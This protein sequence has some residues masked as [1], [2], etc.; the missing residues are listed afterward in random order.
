MKN[1]Y[2]NSFRGENKNSIDVVFLGNSSAYKSITPL[3]IWKEYGYTSFVCGAPA[4]E[5]HEAYNMLKDFMKVQK[6]KIVF[7]E[8]EGIFNSFGKKIKGEYPEL[9]RNLI[10]MS[11]EIDGANEF[12][13]TE[14]EQLCPFLKNH[15]RWSRI[16]FDDFTLTPDYT[17]HYPT[18]GYVIE[19]KVKPYTGTKNYMESSD[20][21]T[22]IQMTV[23][24]YLD[25]IRDICRQNDAELILLSSPLPRAWNDERHKAVQNYA[26]ENGL[27]YIDT[28]LLIKD[29]GIDWKKDSSDDGYHLNINGARKHTA[30]IGRYLSENY[31]LTD[32]RTDSIY[33]QWNNDYEA[34]LKEIKKG[35]KKN[36]SKESQI[37]ENPNSS[38][39][40]ND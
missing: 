5:I 17:Q 15:N 31:K 18:K 25:K 14:T 2:G 24:L 28:N 9:K 37:P 36:K 10:Y 7:Y 22:P 26:D 13:D 39:S 4:Q 16:T 40:V 32:H 33:A 12:L 34:Y 30:F 23:R 21:T 1:Y 27:K 20:F 38:D 35:Q 29:I 19:T 6:P 11:N 3:E 8:A